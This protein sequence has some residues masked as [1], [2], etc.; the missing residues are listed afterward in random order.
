[1]NQR[2]GHNEESPEFGGHE[3]PP[4]LGGIAA[5]LEDLASRERASASPVLED[6][7]FLATRALLV[8]RSERSVAG[9]PG[10]LGWI[11]PMRVA[12]AVGLLATFGAAFLA[13]RSVGP[14]PQDTE[15]R[16]VAEAVQ[17]DVDQWLTT[18]E[19]FE[20]DVSQR[21]DMLYLEAARLETSPDD[22][23]E[24]LATEETSS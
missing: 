22:V 13:V 14:R 20:D 21:I 10:W 6:R 11:T 19:V 18:L 16:L 17:T 7:V 4:E 15:A 2:N 8:Q 1:M 5:A 24:W 12:A 3:L 9:A 23:T